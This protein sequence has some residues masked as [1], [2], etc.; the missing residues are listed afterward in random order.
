M[1]MMQVVDLPML[2]QS[3][4]ALSQKKTEEKKLK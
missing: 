3:L 1:I 2:I 4:A